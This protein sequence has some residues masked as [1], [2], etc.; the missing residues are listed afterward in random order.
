MTDYLQVVINMIGT[1]ENRY[2]DPAAWPRL[3]GELGLKLPADYKSIIDAYA[4]IKLNGHLYLSHPATHRWN[5]GQW[6]QD[7]I[8]AFSDVDWDELDLDPDE[9]PR[10]LFGLEELTFGTPNGLWPLASTDRGET[11]FLAEPGGQGERLI[12]ADGD[13]W[14]A[15]HRTPFAEWLHRYLI[16]DDMTGPNSSAFYPGPVKLE[17]LPMSPGERTQPYHGPDRGM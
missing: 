3:E 2:A 10:E 12:I 11:V 8:R 17:H 4:P 14:W 1:P 16:G 5:L 6:I 9:D 13:G 15:E 7:T